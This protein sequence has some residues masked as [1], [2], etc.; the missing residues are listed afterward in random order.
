VCDSRRLDIE[1]G[2][3]TSGALDQGERGSTSSAGNV[4][5]PAVRVDTE[6]VNHFRSLRRS[7]PILLSD[8]LAEN[9]TPHLGRGRAAKAH[10][11]WTIEIEANA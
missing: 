7:L 3:P 10:I 2:Q 6:K 11:L 8:I 9:L 5:D 1:A 4:E